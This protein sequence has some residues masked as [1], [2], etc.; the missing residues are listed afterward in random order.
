MTVA[1]VVDPAGLLSH[2][3]PEAS[4]GLMDRERGYAPET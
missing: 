1:Q 2:A 3:L 4:P